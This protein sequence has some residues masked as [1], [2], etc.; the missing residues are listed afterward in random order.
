M[1]AGPALDLLAPRKLLSRTWTKMSG[2]TCLAAGPPV[3]S[4]EPCPGSSSSEPAC[5]EDHV[6]DTG[7]VWGQSLSEARGGKRGLCGD[8]KPDWDMLP[9][10]PPSACGGCTW[11]S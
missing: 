6:P 7:L 11:H 9:N 2:G 5:W 1:A 3:P 10:F 4:A 8:V